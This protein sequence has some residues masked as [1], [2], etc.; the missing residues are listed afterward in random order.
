MTVSTLP[1][2]GGTLRSTR[3]ANPVVHE[4]LDWIQKH[5]RVPFGSGVDASSIAH[6]ASGAPFS[7]IVQRGASA[8]SP[9]V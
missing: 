9:P 5:G 3:A 4:A 7:V 2:G 6:A 8:M 1:V